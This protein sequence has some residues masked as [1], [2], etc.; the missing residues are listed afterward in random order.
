METNTKRRDE[1]LKLRSEGKTYSQISNELNC[2]RSLVAFYC[3][4]RY[5]PEKEKEREASKIEYEKIVC[6]AIKNLKNI[7]QVCKFLGKQ[8]TNKNY[9][10][11][12]K[13]IDKY[14]IDTS[15]F[16]SEF[17]NYVFK[18]YP[19]E[20]VYCKNSILKNTNS[21]RKRLLK[22]GLK[23]KKCEC[24]GRSLWNG[25]DIPLE[26]HHINGDNRD[27]RLE[28]LQLL[29]PNCH[30]QTD[31]YCGR[32]KRKTIKKASKKEDTSPSKEELIS[33]FAIYR[34]FSSVAKKY[35][36]SDNAVRKWCAKRGLPIKRKDFLAFLG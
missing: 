6:D 11:V 5:D 32:A 21:L 13:I 28:N 17:K 22:N 35:G 9:Q 34:N 16:T 10:Y 29:C 27:N 24:C 8:A 3:G 1:I 12:K 4:K 33:M 14:N 20:I 25:K 18:S 30:A 26:V 2:N 23:E 31:T 7:N 19:D 36:V 15:H